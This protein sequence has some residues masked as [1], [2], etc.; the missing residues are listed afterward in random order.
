MNNLKLFLVMAFSFLYL[1]ETQ[2]QDINIGTQKI[3]T[4]AQKVV[5]E[6]PYPDSDIDLPIRI[7]LKPIYKWAEKIV[8]TLYTSPNYPNGWVEKGCDTRYQYRFVRGPFNFRAANNTLNI[9]FIG[10]YGVRGSSRLCTGIGNSAWTKACTCG[11]GTEAPR[12]IQAGFTIQF[13]LKPDYT[14]A[15]TVKQQEPKALDKC[16]VCFFGVDIT[17]DVINSLRDE[18]NVSITDMQKQLQSLSLKSYIQTVWDT[19]QAPYFMEDLGY[20]TINPKQLRISQTYLHNDSLFV[21]LGLT[22]KPELQTEL[23]PF[24]KR[25]LPNL[26]DFNQRSGFKLFIAQLLPYSLMNT[27]SNQ[28]AAGKEFTVGKGLLKKTIRIDSLKFQGGV[29][30]QVLMKVYVSRAAR[31]VFYL[32]GKPTFDKTNKIFYLDS[33]DY[34]LDSKQFLL[35]SASWILDDMIVKKLKEYTSISLAGEL[36]ELYK[37]A[38][39]QLNRNIYPGINSK[40]YLRAINVNELA[41]SN[42]GIFIAGMTEGKFWID[43]DAE[44]LIKKFTQ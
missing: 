19:L 36:T 41:A 33:V 21:S 26:T 29:E 43:V 5:I 39:A 34:H 1:Q 9:S 10:T 32:V 14:L 35:R 6:N 27:L 3:D 28:Q 12:K 18:L 20:I 4:L 25:I 31:G 13:S 38:G 15:L 30:G 17:Q 23:Q 37:T 40:G 2:A 24:T 7:N 44:N 16:T 8:D 11:F 42:K 22:A